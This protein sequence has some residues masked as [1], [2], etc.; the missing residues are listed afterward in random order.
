MAE[1]LEFMFAQDFALTG[2]ITWETIV[3]GVPGTSTLQASGTL[4]YRTFLARHGSA[5][6]TRAAPFDLL[7]SV[8]AALGSSFAVNL[9]SN[10]KVVVSNVDA[11]S[12]S[13][14][15]PTTVYRLLGFTS[16]AI[17]LAPNTS[18]TA[19]YYPTHVVYSP[20]YGN[21]SGWQ[22]RAMRRAA[23]RLHTG[24]VYSVQ[25]YAREYTRAV[26]WQFHPKTWSE[27]GTYGEGTPMF[28]P[29]ARSR[30]SYTGEPGQE[31]PWSVLDSMGIQGEQVCG[32][33]FGTLQNLIAAAG[34]QTWFECCV[35]PDT[36][37]KDVPNAPMAA[38]F[39]GRWDFNNVAFSQVS[40]QSGRT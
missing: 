32:V 31:P 5:T 1:S 30:N 33:A 6:G 4:Y 17:A 23:A 7:K 28:P 39:D 38:H 26:H 37:Q 40:E 3:D 36:L 20:N 9:G 29:A 25:S 22:Q 34:D 13:T 11:V 18:T 10:G 35:E 24:H 15:L 16:G 14:A 21:D 27:V 19:T 2:S 12:V 8:A